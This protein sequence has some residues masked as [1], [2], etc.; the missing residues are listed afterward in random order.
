M[1]HRRQAS[2]PQGAE[3]RRRAESPSPGSV[4][5]RLYR[6][7]ASLASRAAHVHDC[8]SRNLNRRS[9]ASTVS[10]RG[11]YR[12]RRH[13]LSCPSVHRSATC[14]CSRVADPRASGSRPSASHAAR[15]M[16][17]PAVIVGAAV[18]ATSR[19]IARRRR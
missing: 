10:A 16:A 15:N 7:A 8:D 6:G 3:L 9:N 14:P 17:S 1:R 12:P 18:T 13:S 5:P 4:V 11:A 19:E 2:Q